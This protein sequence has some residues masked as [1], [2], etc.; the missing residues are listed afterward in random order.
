MPVGFRVLTSPADAEQRKARAALSQHIVQSLDHL[1][2]FQGTGARSDLVA[3]T[4]MVPRMTEG[5]W[6]S[7]GEG[8]VLVLTV[9][10]RDLHVRGGQVIL[11]TQHL[12]GFIGICRVT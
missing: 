11:L 5:R 7:G 8:I 4:C 2:Y 10:Q 12:G 1:A 6:R 3:R 9:D